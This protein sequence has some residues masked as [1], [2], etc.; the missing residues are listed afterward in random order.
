MVGTLTT[1]FLEDRENRSRIVRCRD[2]EL[3]G[4]MWLVTH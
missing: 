2:L 1:G 4:Q 3:L